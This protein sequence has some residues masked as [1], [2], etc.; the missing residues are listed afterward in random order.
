[1]KKIILFLGVI[2]FSVFLWSAPQS[3]VYVS[4]ENAQIKTEPKTFAQTVKSAPYGTQ[5]LVLSRPKKSKWIQ[6]EIVN[7]NSQTGWILQT[8]ISEKKIIPSKQISRIGSKDKELA[9]AGKGFSSNDDNFV[10]NYTGPNYENVTLIEQFNV[11][12]DELQNFIE[13]GKLNEGAE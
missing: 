13:D 12:Q 6:V 8:S 9:L 5:L 7:A 3:Y 2:T 1:M 4:T 11:D 10:S